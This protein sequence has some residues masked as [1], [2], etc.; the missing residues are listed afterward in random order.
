MK[1]TKIRFAARFAV[2]LCL[3]LVFG[4][5]LSPPKALSA[6][7]QLNFRFRYLGPKTFQEATYETAVAD[8]DGDGHL[9]I[10]VPLVLAGTIQIFRGNGDG[11]FAPP[12]SYP[13]PGFVVSIVADDFNGDGAPDLAAAAIYGVGVLI[14]LND[15]SGG[16]GNQSTLFPAGASPNQVRVADFNGDGKLDLT[17]PD[18]SAGT[19]QVLLGDGHGSFGAPISSPN[20]GG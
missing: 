9:D 5:L 13:A 4:S 19:N 11:T 2:G 6:G 12:V 18:F 1:T 17:V 16:F 3:L 14:F 15:G 7:C 10:A 8:F 20:G